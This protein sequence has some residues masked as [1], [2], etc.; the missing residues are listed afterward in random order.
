MKFVRL[1]SQYITLPIDQRNI[2]KKCVQ[3]HEGNKEDAKSK[4]T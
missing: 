2:Q 1:N 4:K 3:K